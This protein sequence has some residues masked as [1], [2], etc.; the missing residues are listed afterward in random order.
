[1]QIFAEMCPNPSEEIFAVFIFA[2]RKR[3]ALTTPLPDD[4]HAPYARVT[5]E[6]TLNDNG[7]LFL[8]C[9]VFS[10]YESIKTACRCGLKTG[11]LSRRFS[12]ADLNF[13]NFQ[14]SLMGSL[15]PYTRVNKLI[16]LFQKLQGN[17]RLISNMHLIRGEKIDHTPKTATPLW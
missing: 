17:M 11:L 3:D 10:N 2:E 1:M 5:E 14:A 15:V 16:R 6:M 12:T 8:L 13:D 9:R 7:L 4:T